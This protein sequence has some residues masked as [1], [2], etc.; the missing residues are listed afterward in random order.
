MTWRAYYR[1]VLRRSVNV[2]W[3][4]IGD[5]SRLATLTI[6][7]LLITVAVF[8]FIEVHIPMWGWRVTDFSALAGTFLLLFF[9]VFSVLRFIFYTP[10]LMHQE[11][12]KKIDDQ[13]KELDT[14]AL[15]LTRC[16]KFA[17]LIEEGN[18][19]DRKCHTTSIPGKAIREWL[20]KFKKYLGTLHPMYITEW[21]KV[22]DINL[23]E[24]IYQRGAGSDRVLYHT[25]VSRLIQ[26]Q[27]MLA[28]W[29]EQLEQRG[30]VPHETNSTIS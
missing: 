30:L 14:R 20:N 3:S 9:I 1:Q 29:R 4:L 16:E 8:P 23:R 27:K 12:E 25:F 11:Q 5:L 26:S 6:G 2:S 7:T 28:R 10:Y 21:E 18:D 24:P 15:I 19:I 17:E 22:Y 13:N